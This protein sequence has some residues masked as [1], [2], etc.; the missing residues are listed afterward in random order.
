MRR[1][2]GKAYTLVE[3]LVVVALTVVVLGMA[4]D[5]YI[6]TIRATNAVSDQLVAMREAQSIAQQIEK[7][8]RSRVPSDNGETFAQREMVFAVAQAAKAPEKAK[9]A[10]AAVEEGTLTPAVKNVRVSNDVERRRV[11]LSTAGD[12][13]AEKKQ[14]L[15]SNSD[16]FCAEVVFRYAEDVKDFSPQ[17]KDQATTVPQLTNVIVRV[18]P[19]L[20]G[21]GSFEEARKANTPRFAELE[22]WV[23][24]R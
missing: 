12:N 3:A 5:A 9:G 22:L 15:G 21:M 17:W 6:E 13:V 7:L 2:V 19:R 23:R 8:L 18:W 11:L 4:L 24:M 10:S 1:P 20:A 16:A 14:V